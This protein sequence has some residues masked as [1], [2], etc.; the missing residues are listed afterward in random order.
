MHRGAGTGVT[1]TNNGFGVLEHRS[2]YIYTLYILYTLPPSQS[3]QQQRS[4]Q[5]QHQQ[6]RRQHHHNQHSSSSSTTTT[7][8]NINTAAAAAASSSST[9]IPMTVMHPP[10][11]L[12]PPAPPSRSLSDRTHPEVLLSLQVGGYV[13][14]YVYVYVSVYM[15]LYVCV[16]MCVYALSDRMHPQVLQSLQVGG[17][18]VC[19]CV[20]Y[21]CT[22]KHPSI[23]PS[24]HTCMLIFIHTRHGGSGACRR[25][26]TRAACTW[27][28]MW[29]VGVWVRVCVWGDVCV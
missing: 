22:R 19:G 18:S 13:Y 29:L 10:A 2:I 3:Q 8:T 12:T 21:I 27:L 20:E 25:R 26:W 1:G 11:G 9:S 4:Q 16:C 15:Y 17:G 14:I 23:H 28:G 5:Q 24:I 6:H 7:T